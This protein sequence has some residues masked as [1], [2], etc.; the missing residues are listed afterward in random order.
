MKLRKNLLD[1]DP[2]AVL[3]PILAVILALAFGGVILLAL[4]KNPV[5]AYFAMLDGAFGGDVR[6]FNTINRAIP[7]L[8][9]AVGICIAF[10]G[11]VINIGAEGQLLI[12]AASVTATTL[13]IG[14]A[15]PSVIIIPLALLIGF[16][17][18]ALWGAIPGYLKARFDVNEILTTIMMNEIAIQ[19]VI[20]LLS[21]PMIDPEQIA[22][23]T[24]IAQSAAIPEAA[25]LLRLAPPARLHAGIFLALIAAVVVYILL[26]RTVTGYRIRAVGQSKAASLYAG[27]SVPVYL[28]LAMVFSGGLA[29]LAGASE[30][31]GV[32]HRM[33]EGFAVGYGFSGI[34]VA[35]FGRLHPIG[36][37]P[38]AIFFAALLTGAERMQRELQVPS[39]TI[40]V[41]QGLVVLFVVSSE[42][43]IR[44]RAARRAAQ[45]ITTTSVEPEAS[46]QQVVSGVK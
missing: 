8:L 3:A 42:V 34:V 14:E 5:E 7:L 4:G 22:L 46:I 39:A 26:W 10:R 38:S 11:G 32:N 1:G 13:A 19:F 21:G 16:A 20:F 36:A 28:T 23:G 37:I 15:L 2:L 24:R 29:G 9:V 6:I 17:G 12:G 45:R 25:W 18:G 43:L 31:M 44:R 30:L 35:L 40:T 27:I 33:L 41:L